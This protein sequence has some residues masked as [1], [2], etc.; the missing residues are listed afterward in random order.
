MSAN[1]AIP[2]DILPTNQFFEKQTGEPDNATKT[3]VA[4]LI[5][6]TICSATTQLEEEAVEKQLP[7]NH[8]EAA[9]SPELEEKRKGG[10]AFEDKEGREEAS[11]C[12]ELE[13][14]TGASSA[15]PELEEGP[16]DTLN[17]SELEEEP[18]EESA[19]PKLEEGPE[20]SH[21]PDL[22]ELEYTSASPEEA[23]PSSDQEELEDTL[24]TLE[25]IEKLEDTSVIPEENV[26]FSDRGGAPE[27]AF[28]TPELE[29]EPRDAS[30]TPEETSAFPEQEP[31]GVSRTC[32]QRE[33]HQKEDLYHSICKKNQHVVSS[34][35]PPE[36]ECVDFSFS[37]REQKSQLI[38]ETGK[39]RQIVHLIISRIV[40][41]IYAEAKMVRHYHDDLLIVLFEYIWDQVQNED[42]CISDQTFKKMDKTIHQ[43]LCKNM[44][45]PNKV[46]FLLK[47]SEDSVVADCMISIVKKLLIRPSKKPNVIS[48]FFSSLGQCLQGCFYWFRKILQQAT[49]S[50]TSSESKS[51]AAHFPPL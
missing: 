3:A 51:P 39:K 44:G 27:I 15:T 14:K 36:E 12:L 2:T 40:D 16:E 23:S 8:K 33:N 46:V 42:L 35:R 20:A 32:H 13:E 47:Y 38:D 41:H 29:D 49:K 9:S 50:Q 6:D 18:E 28:L 25:L 30:A 4:A 34:C 43:T 22:E 19:A 17:F 7:V 37:V 24:T 21:S 45:S 1:K 10:L 31:E 5:I 48:R 11:D 26:V